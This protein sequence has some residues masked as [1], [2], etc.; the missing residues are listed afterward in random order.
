MLNA[1]ITKLLLARSEY[2]DPVQHY[3][4]YVTTPHSIL[5]CGAHLGEE[6][7]RYRQLGIGK[8]F[9]N[10]AQPN[11]VKILEEKFGKKHVFSGVLSN[12]D[13]DVIDFYLT[14]NS[15]SSS[16]RVIEPINDWNIRNVDKVKL[17]SVTLDSILQKI[18][19]GKDELPKLIVLD[20][21]GGEFEALENSKLAIHNHSDFVVEMAQYQLYVQQKTDCDIINF[22]KKFGYCLVFPKNK[23]EH[24]D[25]LFL[26]PTSQIKYFKKHAVLKR[27]LSQKKSKLVD[28]LYQVKRKLKVR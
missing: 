27:F 20:L 22:F 14:N 19:I 7:V 9:W 11:L 25:G 5:H 17:K 13:N 3:V 2:D 1:R 16:T 4:K 26:S 28:F 12:K 24:Y 18:L 15:L 10:E 6:Y 8:I 23:K 21:Q